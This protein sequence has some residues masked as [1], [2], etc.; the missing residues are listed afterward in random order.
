M[1]TPKYDALRGLAALWVLAAHTD[2]LLLGERFKLSGHYAVLVFFLLSGFLVTQSIQSNIRAH[3]AFAASSYLVSRCA[4][5]YPPLIGSIAL[6]WL[7]DLVGT[8]LRVKVASY[9]ATHALHLI[10]GLANANVPLWTLYI[11]VQLYAGAG[12]F[13]AAMRAASMRGRVCG[14]IVC[15]VLVTNWLGTEYVFWALVW[16]TGAWFC[17]R[18]PTRAMAYAT[19]GAIVAMHFLLGDSHL[20]VLVRPLELAISVLAAVVMFHGLPGSA[21]RCLAWTGDWSYSLYVVHWPVL[22]ALQRLEFPWWISVPLGLA[23]TVFVAISFAMLFER[24][25]LLKQRP[26]AGASA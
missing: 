5:I 4:R 1:K 21:P 15:A 16:L 9:D 3:G 13:A 10:Y 17:L 7:L 20:A 19:S 25:P 26:V 18:P 6:V 11:E 2:Q 8:G 12:A 22:M 14:G 23:G 24:A